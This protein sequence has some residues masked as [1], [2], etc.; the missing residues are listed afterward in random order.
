MCI[1]ASLAISRETTRMDGQSISE[2]FYNK[3][4]ISTILFFSTNQLLVN[5]FVV[6]KLKDPPVKN[7]LREL[8]CKMM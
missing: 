7:L 1:P 4:Q 8:Y 6:Y 3:L 5:G 2:I